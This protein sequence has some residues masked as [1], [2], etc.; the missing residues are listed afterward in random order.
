[1]YTTNQLMKCGYDDELDLALPITT[2]EQIN[3]YYETD[4]SFNKFKKKITE[5]SNNIIK[6][7]IIEEEMHKCHSSEKYTQLE[8]IKAKLTKF[9]DDHEKK[10]DLIQY[11]FCVNNALCQFDNNTSCENC[12]LSKQLLNK[13]YYTISDSV[14]IYDQVTSVCSIL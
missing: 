1:M 8:K 12:T 5:F 11:Q 7:N 4:E 13:V 6:L 3:A 9:I 14:S 10:S 2:P